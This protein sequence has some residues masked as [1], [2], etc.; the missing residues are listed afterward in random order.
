MWQVPSFGCARGICLKKALITLAVVII[1]L[2]VWIFFAVLWYQ[3]VTPGGPTLTEHLTKFPAPER[4]RAFT[5]DG[6]KYL[7]LD[8]ALHP[9]PRF[10]SGPPLYIF[11]S[12]GLLAD[13][14]PDSGDSGDFFKKW[15]GIL[16]ATR[17]EPLEF[18]KW[19]RAPRQ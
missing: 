18:A 2:G 4:Q 12:S 11:D 8:G 15:P 6:Q 5:Q 10:P 1:L 9:L 17:I 3:S 13:W 19:Q 7:V 14:T 16:D